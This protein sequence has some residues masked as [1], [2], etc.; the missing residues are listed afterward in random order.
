MN[1]K[2]IAGKVLPPYFCFS[3]I[4]RQ[5]KTS[6]KKNNSVY[7]NIQIYAWEVAWQPEEYFVPNNWHRNLN[8]KHKTF[9]TNKRKVVKA[10]DWTGKNTLKDEVA[11]PRL[12]VE[13]L[14]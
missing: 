13:M 1:L 3:D 10:E 14:V 5:R 8:I 2:F 6:T 11:F 12:P 9:H 4:L 7:F